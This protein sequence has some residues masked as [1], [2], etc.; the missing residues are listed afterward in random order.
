MGRKQIEKIYKKVKA[1]VSIDYWIYMYFKDNNIN[2]SN[3][4]NELLKQYIKD[5]NQK[6]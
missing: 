3:I 2:L 1:G 5:L 6:I 4:T